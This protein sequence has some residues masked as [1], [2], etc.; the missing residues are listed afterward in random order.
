MRITAKASS[1]PATYQ[2]KIGHST[3]RRQ[4]SAR[5]PLAV[6]WMIENS[7]MPVATSK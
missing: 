2:Q 4:C 1:A 7:T 6:S 5:Q 3:K